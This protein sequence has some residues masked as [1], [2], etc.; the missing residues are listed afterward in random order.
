MGSNNFYSG[1]LSFPGRLTSLSLAAPNGASSVLAARNEYTMSFNAVPEPSTLGLLACGA[2][3]MGGAWY[4][5]RKRAG[6][7]L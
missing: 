2:L 1:I 5:R 7:S 4:R 6:G 3:G